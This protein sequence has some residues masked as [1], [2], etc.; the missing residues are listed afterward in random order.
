MRR[1]HFFQEVQTGVITAFQK[2]I[3]T[4]LGID[5]IIFDQFYLSCA[6]SKL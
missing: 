4:L 3:L 6:V 5:Y 2:N 1:G